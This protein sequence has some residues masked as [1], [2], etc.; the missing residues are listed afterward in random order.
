[1]KILKNL[2]KI[3]ITLVF[4]VVEFFCVTTAFGMGG[5]YW[6]GICLLLDWEATTFS[7]AMAS[8]GGMVV[9]LYILGDI[10]FILECEEKIIKSIDKIK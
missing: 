6:I 7:F 8:L 4:F 5:A 10:S 1:M 2:L 9:F 3:I